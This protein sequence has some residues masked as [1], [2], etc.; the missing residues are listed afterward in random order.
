MNPSSTHASLLLSRNLRRKWA[1]AATGASLL[2][3]GLCLIGTGSSASASLGP[4]LSATADCNSVTTCFTPQ[5][6]DVA[7]G[8]TPLLAKGIDGKGET[9]I[10]PELAETQASYPEVSDLRL[11]FKK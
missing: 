6:I 11:D 1:V 2:V 3:G 8:V 5:Q 7:Y 9:V 4:R 10:L